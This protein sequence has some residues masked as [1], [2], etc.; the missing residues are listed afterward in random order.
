MLLIHGSAVPKPEHRDYLIE[1]AAKITR[2]TQSDEGCLFYEFSIS[3]DGR[4][5]NSVEIW[6]DREALD[7]HMSHPH[8]IEFMNGLGDIF[9]TPPTMTESKLN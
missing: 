8:T 1:A 7:A 2:A 4:A 5:I 9:V 6:R 3:L